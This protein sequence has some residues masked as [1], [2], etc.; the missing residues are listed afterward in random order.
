[1]KIS[2]EDFK[3]DVFKQR[4]GN[5]NLYEIIND[6]GVKSSRFC[7]IQNLTVKS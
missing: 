4:I 3:E 7:Y 5:E 2:L 6:N 1:M